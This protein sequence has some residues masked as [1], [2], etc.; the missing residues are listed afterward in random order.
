MRILRRAEV[1]E[2]IGLSV[3]TIRRLEQAQSFP[4]RIKLSP[5]AVGYREDQVREWIASRDVVTQ[6]GSP[7]QATKAP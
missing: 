4:R 1:V 5:Q 3:S 7:H 6:S 2:L